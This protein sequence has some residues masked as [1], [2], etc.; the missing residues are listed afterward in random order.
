MQV[1]TKPQ[2][3]DLMIDGTKEYTWLGVNDVQ[4]LLREVK[5]ELETHKK[6]LLVNNLREAVSFSARMRLVLATRLQA[7]HSPFRLH[8][9]SN[10]PSILMNVAHGSFHKF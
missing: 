7:Q 4:A 5:Q 6:M 9:S 1:L 10:T 8:T 3:Y 2:R